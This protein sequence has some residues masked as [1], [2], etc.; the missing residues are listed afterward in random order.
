MFINIGDSSTL[1]STG[2]HETT[3]MTVS[4]VHTVQNQATAVG[5]TVVHMLTYSVK[6]CVAKLQYEISLIK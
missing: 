3:F 4:N 2:K 6:E 1:P 5:K